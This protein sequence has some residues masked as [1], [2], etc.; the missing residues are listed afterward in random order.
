MRTHA[1][2]MRLPGR[3]RIATPD[4]PRFGR[5]AWAA[6]IV[7]HAAALALL[8]TTFR[9]ADRAGRRI[10][11][12]LAPAPA[13]T[14]PPPADLPAARPAVRPL[15]SRPP[16]APVR[17]GAPAARPVPFRSAPTVRPFL[18]TTATVR[19]FREGSA[20]PDTAAAAEEGRRQGALAMATRQWNAA[21]HGLI[22][23]IR[24]EMFL[25]ALESSPFPRR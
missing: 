3:E 2:S 13:W 23:E 9:P 21:F 14:A 12:A 4:R 11:V 17:D 10:P 15:P 1:G 22:P 6:A 16:R 8:M 24:G 18:T 20:P 7:L 5:T 19:A 25:E